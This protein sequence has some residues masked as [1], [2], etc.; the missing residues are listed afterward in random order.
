MIFIIS[1]RDFL[2]A[3]EDF[4]SVHSTYQ[5]HNYPLGPLPKLALAMP[6]RN[7][8]AQYGAHVVVALHYLEQRYLVYLEQIAQS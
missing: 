7:G 4:H 5:D 1:I 8:S 3:D 6:D 2:V